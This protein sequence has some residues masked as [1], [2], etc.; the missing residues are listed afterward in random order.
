MLCLF[1]P[2]Y[3]IATGTRP[4]NVIMPGMVAIITRDAQVVN[5]IRAAI[6]LGNQMLDGSVFF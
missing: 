4:L 5:S 6:P 1:L 3:L 2:T